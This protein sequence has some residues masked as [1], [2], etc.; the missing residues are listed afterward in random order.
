MLERVAIRGA[1]FHPE[2]FAVYY[3]R[4]EGAA[5]ETQWSS[6]VWIDLA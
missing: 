3:V 6:P 1:P 5:G 2:P 4:I